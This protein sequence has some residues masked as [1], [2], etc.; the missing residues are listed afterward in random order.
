MQFEIAELCF[1]LARLAQEAK[2]VPVKQSPYSFVSCRDFRQQ[3]YLPRCCFFTVLSH[4]LC[5]KILA[6]FHITMRL[7][8]N[9]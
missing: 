2:K 3:L 6:G 5:S 1:K 8:A 4:I 7:K 9:P